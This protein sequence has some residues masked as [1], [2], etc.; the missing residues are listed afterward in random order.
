MEE[1]IR[2]AL[3]KEKPEVQQMVEEI[4]KLNMLQKKKNVE[5]TKT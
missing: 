4:E 1:S 5:D 3:A 2:K